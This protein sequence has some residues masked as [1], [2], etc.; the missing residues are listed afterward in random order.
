MD[1]YGLLKP[2]I[3]IGKGKNAHNTFQNVIPVLH[4]IE[5]RNS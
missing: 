2:R 3:P 5:E 1:I 4:N